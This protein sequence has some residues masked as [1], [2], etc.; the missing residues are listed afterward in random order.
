MAIDRININNFKSIRQLNDFPIH[1]LNVLIGSNGAGKSNFIAFFKLLNSISENK[2]PNYIADNSYADR[3][4]YFGKKASKE[5][6]SGSIIFKADN[7]NGNTN[8]CYE[9]K[10]NPFLGKIFFSQ[11][12]CKKTGNSCQYNMITNQ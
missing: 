12:P 7:K 8:N 11:P 3:V 1:P 9:C 2:L 6:M 5:R 4:L 10:G